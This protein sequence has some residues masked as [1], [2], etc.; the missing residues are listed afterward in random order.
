MIKAGR[1]AVKALSERLA[2][3]RITG[4]LSM[5]ILVVAMVEGVEEEGHVVM[6]HHR[7]LRL[8]AQLLVSKWCGN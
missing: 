7:V 6:L 3:G 5:Q 8:P 4:L 2:A 1:S